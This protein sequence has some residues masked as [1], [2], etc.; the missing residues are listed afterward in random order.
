MAGGGRH[1]ADEDCGHGRKRRVGGGGRR[2]HADAVRGRG[3]G[4]ALRKRA[5]GRAAGGRRVGDFQL[6]RRGHG[7]A[8]GGNNLCAADVDPDDFRDDAEL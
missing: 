5:A 4:R 2:V 1:P 7:G 3:I 8:V 6:R